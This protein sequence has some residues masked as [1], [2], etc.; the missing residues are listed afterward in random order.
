MKHFF[1]I[2]IKF[3]K[4]S[5]LCENNSPYGRRDSTQIVVFPISTHADITVYQHGKRFIFLKYQLKIL[6]T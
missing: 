3:G 4:N 1:G 5:K 6:K 2:D